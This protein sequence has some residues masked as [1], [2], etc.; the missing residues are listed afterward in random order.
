MGKKDENTLHNGFFKDKTI[1]VTGGTGTIGT[2]IVSQ[3]MRNSPKAIRIFS[4]DENGLFILQ[5]ELRFQKNLR[6][7]FG[8]VRDKDRLRMAC[9]G[10]DV[11]FHA[12]ALKHVPICEYNPFDAVRTNVI[13][14]QN[15]I[16][17]AL[18]ENVEN[19]IFIS[20]DKAVNPTS[21]MGASKLLCEKLVVEA[22]SYRGKRRT[23]FSCV[24]FGNVLGSRGSVTEVF[25][26]QIE[27][28]EAVTIT[29]PE[30]TRFI[31][32]STQAVGLVFRAAEIAEGGETFI[33]KM[34]GLRI[35][36]L[37]EVM[38]EELSSKPVKSKI[39][40]V[41]L[42]AGEKLHEELLTAFE[43]SNSAEL[44]DMFVINSRDALSS[45]RTSVNSSCNNSYS[46]KDVQLLSKPEISKML[47]IAN[48]I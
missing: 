4:N 40:V 44:A 47:K 5:Q 37:A 6:F 29:H 23:K 43:M 18:L 28:G 24:R 10:V 33:L 8:D 31:M 15:L 22:C 34:P 20:T 16:E 25:K 46:S 12:A 39:K 2:E 35:L 36:D 3:L 11:V 7:L 38:I 42:R 19:F 45:D 17:V 26:H 21:T 48:I 1:L 14:T 13:G 41:G 30:M 9:E 32:L 27:L